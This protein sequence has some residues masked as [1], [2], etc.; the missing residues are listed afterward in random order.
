MS[1][2]TPSI[3]PVF[4]V[5]FGFSELADSQALNTELHQLF[6]ARERE[7]SRHANP[8]PY[9]TRNRPLF[10]SVFDLFEWPEACVQR[11]RSFCHDQLLGFVGEMNGY[12]PDQL[13][14]LQPVYDSW[15]HITRRDG[16]F[17]LHNHPMASWSGVYCV[18]SGRDDGTEPDSGRLCFVN[19]HIHAS[20]YVD[21]MNARLRPPFSTVA[22]AGWQLRP[23]Q[24]VLFPSWM[25][26][27][28]KPF[29]GEGE[30]VT[31]A[32]NAWDAASRSGRA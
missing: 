10:E 18:S 13:A 9:T 23:G 16:Y 32:F 2:R 8:R 17:S 27:E 14:A 1:A 6:L 19:P 26:H 5:A 3:H 12:L 29:I 30:R 28:V 25:L 20:M 4:S 15:F 24:L 31:V 21:A 11:L 7:G 22:G